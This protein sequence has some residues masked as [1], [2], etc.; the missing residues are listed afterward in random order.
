[1][2]D[3]VRE[4]KN[5]VPEKKETKKDGE[6]LDLD[7]HGEKL[8]EGDRADLMVNCRGSQGKGEDHDQQIKQLEGFEDNFTTKRSHW[9]NLLNLIPHRRTM[10]TKDLITGAAGAS[11]FIRLFQDKAPPACDA[12]HPV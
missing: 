7:P 10:N 8:D 4:E 9:K 12:K 11:S 2:N 5:E 3:E 6:V 1:M